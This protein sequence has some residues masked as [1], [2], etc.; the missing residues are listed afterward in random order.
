[1]KI[2]FIL[3]LC[4]DFFSI[5]AAH[6]VGGEMTYEYLGPGAASNTSI[7]RITLKLFRDQLTTGAP[8]PVDVSIGVFNNDNGQQIPSPEPQNVYFTVPRKAESSV[9]VNPFPGC[10]TNPPT[11][12]YNVGIYELT[13]TL[14]NNLKGYSAAYQTCCRVNPLVNVYNSQGVGGTGSTYSCN[15]PPVQDKSPTF[16]ASID[17]LCRKKQFTLFFSASDADGDSLVYEFAPAYNGGAAP[18]STNINPAPPPY[19]SVSYIN[20][21]TY[22][23]PLGDEAS[24]DPS[25]GIISG[26]APEIGKYV[27]CVNVKSYRGGKLIGEHRKDFIVN[28]TDCDFAGVQLDPRGVSCDGFNVS[29]RNYN[30]SPLNKTYFWTFGDPASGTEDTSTLKEPVH[31][32]SDTGVFV[33]KLVVNKGEQCSDSATQI[34]RVY[35]GFFPKLNKTGRCIN[36]PIR[37]TD[38][39]TTNYGVVDSWRWDFGDPASTADTSRNRNPT[40]TYSA[41]GDFTVQLTVTNS[42]GC[43]KT[44]RDTISIVDKPTF[45]ITP[46]TLICSIDSLQLT[47]SGIGTINW[48]PAYNISNPAAFNPI[49][50]PK[51][52]TTYTATLTETPGCVNSQSVTVNV[53]DKVTLNAGGDTTICQTDSARLAISS[54]AL[55]YRWTPAG[56]IVSDTAKSPIVFPSAT[57]IYNV[58]AN[59]GKCTASGTKTVNVVPYPQAN[60][61]NDTTIC[62]PGTVQLIA[63]GGSVYLWSPPNFLSDP[64][65]YNPISTPGQSI[66]YT[67]AVSDNKGCPKPA[68]ASITIN[69]DQIIADA[70][71]RDTIV[72]QSQPLQL[73]GSGAETFLWLPPT[74]LNNNTSATP[75]AVLQQ[76]QQYVLTAQSAAGCSDTDTID[77]IVYKVKPGLYV[78]NA[79]TPNGDGLNDIF[80]PRAIGMKSIKYFRVYDRRGKL[81]FSTDRMN[82]GWDGTFKGKPQDS[83]V[84]VWIA[85]GEDYQGGHIFQKGTITLI[86]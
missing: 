78:P 4:C 53:V 12:N 51:V 81:I 19:G 6:I 74:G 80:T 18:N 22:Q 29:F 79:F 36:S 54:D 65:I 38:Q 75:V 3:V 63:S 47:S 61:G 50:Y 39:T 32:Y 35:P 30:N 17:A 60:A 24:I 21:F 64:G 11:L 42:K 82:R 68:F 83:Q 66:K 25:T 13:I 1:M 69:V 56:A 84:Y 37:F 73:K 67:V 2:V 52:T 5:R 8:M 26:I 10:I 72:V 45:A 86:R 85:D 7:Y 77:V 20:N 44:L 70:G 48:S 49:V 33:Y 41:L 62:F 34:M 31:V 71:P 43:V 59:I 76:N 16:V 9:K 40:Y 57:T 58:S 14:P 28:V 23:T 46:D 27:V 55:H 15:I